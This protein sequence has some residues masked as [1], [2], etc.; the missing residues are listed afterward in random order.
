MQSSN[1]V[2]LCYLY[3]TFMLFVPYIYVICTVHLLFVP[4]IYVICTVHLYY[5]YRT[6]M[7]FV[8]YIC[9][10]YR[11]FMLFVP[12]IYVICTVHL[13]YLYRIFMLFV[14][15]IYVICTVHFLYYIKSC[16]DKCTSFIFCYLIQFVLKIVQHV[17]NY[18]NSSSGTQLFIT[19][20]IDVRYSL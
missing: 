16:S 15:Y 6:F 11:T 10:L 1:R 7:L 19:P 13:C 2:I 20:A 4:Y 3:R 17:S 18:V 9:Y 8:P 5:L 14:P 12:Y